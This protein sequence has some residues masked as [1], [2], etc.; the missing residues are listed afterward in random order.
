MKNVLFIFL[1]INLIFAQVVI[2]E[3]HYNPGSIQ[4]TDADFEFLELYNAGMSPVNLTGW[5]VGSTDT[6]PAILDGVT[7]DSESF[8]VVAYTGASYAGLTVPVIDNG[9]YFG[10]G[11]SGKTLQLINNG[12]IVDEV[13]YDDTAPWPTDPD[14]HG[15]SL[16]LIDPLSDNSLVESWAASLDVG[17][18]P[19]AQ[20]SVYIAPGDNYPP[21]AIAGDDFSAGSGETVLLDG[22]ASY[23]PDGTIVYY[24]WEQTAGTSVT[25]TDAESPVASFIAPASGSLSF[26]LTVYD[27]EAAFDTDD[28][29]ITICS[30]G[31]V[32]IAD[33]RAMG[34][35]QCVNIQGVV[36]TPSFQGS[37]AGEYA[38]QDASAGIILY[39]P[40]LDLG[41]MVGDEV[42]VNGTT[43]EYNGKFEIIVEDPSQVTNLGTTD[44]PV[45]QIIT[46]SDLAGNGEAYESELITIENVFLS[47]GAWPSSGSSVNLDITDDGTSI[48]T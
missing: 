28:V 21:V 15:P 4:G 1:A 37:S 13:T 25:I 24:I 5:T 17:G 41:L 31:T 43:D 27:D 10:L 33:A 6:S 18:T 16:E 20:N 39:A 42:L 34:L 38:V 32:S 19:G 2:N 44:L 47:S 46:V 12:T 40:D 29:N 48:V 30:S 14:G 7:I 3:I 36:T 9:G 11:N 45:P 22:S 35:D 8:V 26:Q 23:D